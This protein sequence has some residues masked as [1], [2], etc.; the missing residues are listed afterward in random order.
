MTQESRARKYQIWINELSFL[1][2]AGSLGQYELTGIFE[3]NSATGITVNL[4]YASNPHFRIHIHHC[5]AKSVH[6]KHFFTNENFSQRYIHDHGN[7]L[8]M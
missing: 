1:L 4:E 5:S 3:R 6:E 8:Y 2:S 7:K